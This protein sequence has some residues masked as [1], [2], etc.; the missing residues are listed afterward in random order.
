MFWLWDEVK[1][2]RVAANLRISS[3]LLVIGPKS[4]TSPSG[5]LSR[6]HLLSRIDF[7]FPHQ[8]FSSFWKRWRFR[9]SERGPYDPFL[10]PRTDLA[11]NEFDRGIELRI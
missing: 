11:H 2:N 10:R 7:L 5:S 3:G 6:Y 1:G 9:P 8:C 4:E